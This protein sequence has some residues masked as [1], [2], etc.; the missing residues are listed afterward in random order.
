MKNIKELDKSYLNEFVKLDRLAFKELNDKIKGHDS[1]EAKKYFLINLEKGKIFGYFID[2]KLVGCIGIIIE[3]KSEY[4]EIM[5]VLVHPE[6]QRKGI[7][8]EL[9]NFAEKIAKTVKLKPKP[10]YLRLNVKYEN[11]KAIRFY[12]KEGFYK[13][14]YVMGKGLKY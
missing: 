6:F 12:E 3:D 1:K 11:K 8:K 9:M 2:K 13:H 10:K 4:L 5:H 14:A 7:G